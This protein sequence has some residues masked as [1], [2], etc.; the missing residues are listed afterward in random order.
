MDLG[1]IAYFLLGWFKMHTVRLQEN[2]HVTTK[3]AWLKSCYAY[4]HHI[5]QCSLYGFSAW[6]NFD[7]NVRS[8][9]EPEMVVS[10]EIG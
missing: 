5:H 6:A 7:N 1:V 8:A 10:A 4:S 2:M 9:F 3:K